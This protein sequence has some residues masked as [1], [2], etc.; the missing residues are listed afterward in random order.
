MLSIILPIY[1][2]EAFVAECL[3]SIVA[4]TYR[5]FE[6]IVVDDC[7]TD[8]SMTIVEQYVQKLPMRIVHHEQNRGLSVARNT[9]LN[10]AQGDYVLFV[11]SDDVLASDCLQTLHSEAVTTNVDV[12]V[13]NLDT[14]GEQK[15]GFVPHLHCTVP[16][17]LTNN[18]DVL[19][20]YMWGDCYVMAW[21]KLLKRSFLLQNKIFFDEGLLHEDNTWSV[22]VAEH[23]HS[24]ALLPN[25]TYHYRLRQ[26]SLQTDRDFQRHFEA[27]CHIIT[28]LGAEIKNNIDKFEKLEWE[29]WL[30]RQKALFFKQAEANG[31]AEQISA[32]Y[33]I[34]RNTLPQYKFDKFFAHYWLPKSIGQRVFSRLCG[35]WLM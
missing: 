19:R 20:N 31:T 22:R 9:G 34:V 35:V 11:D 13:G 26:G 10:V 6:V 29:G 18:A 30:E 33:Q 12:V 28:L 17:V 32:L 15:F 21:N 27:Y 25:V 8:K 5:N 23:A 14:L 7:S 24:M 3:D 2:V 4:Q 1:N 16:I